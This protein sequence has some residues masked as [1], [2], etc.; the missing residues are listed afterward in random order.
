[1][2]RN[3]DGG[4]DGRKIKVGGKGEKANYSPSWPSSLDIGSSE[5][6]LY[7]GFKTDRSSEV[8]YIPETRNEK[9]LMEIKD[10]PMNLGKNKISEKT[11]MGDSKH[12]TTIE[13][14][15]IPKNINGR[16]N[17]FRRKT[18]EETTEGTPIAETQIILP[19]TV[20]YGGSL[21]NEVLFEAIC[22]IESGQIVP[23]IT[24]EMD[25]ES[26][27]MIVE[28]TLS[29]RDRIR[30]LEEHMNTVMREIVR[31]KKENDELTE[32]IDDLE[33]RREKREKQSDEK[34]ARKAQKQ[35]KGKGKEVLY[36]PEIIPVKEKEIPR[37][38][39]P[40]IMR[41][42]NEES[43]EWKARKSFAKFVEG[44]NKEG[45]QE[46][47]KKSE[48]KKMVKLGE[49]KKVYVAPE[50]ER[51]LSIRFNRRKNGR[52]GLPVQI[53]TET[54]RTALNEI[55]KGLNVE[56]YFTKADKTRMGDI[57]MCLAK[58]RAA[59]IVE[60]KEAMTQC[61]KQRGLEE[62]IFVPD[63]KKVKVYINDVPLKE[64][65]TEKTGNRKTG[66]MNIHLIHWQLT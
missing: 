58:P 25:T 39:A 61:L 50:Q 63:M 8:D 33:S 42:R 40:V 38:K 56:G 14:T 64:T 11:R 23:A 59:D 55:L 41:D 20:A 26:E 1:M 9:K 3:Q 66:T 12:A 34:E 47:V 28:S 35:D 65:G 32:R 10:T 31:I 29:D 15:A 22:E 7:K 54:I 46:V 2:T 43:G 49:L 51:R 4:E 57:H 13:V 48:R 37:L 45:F 27:V 17:R 52:Q 18:T 5:R 30:T 62:C 21:V 44:A 53:T 36:I 60:A 6:S 19:S 24:D 16:E